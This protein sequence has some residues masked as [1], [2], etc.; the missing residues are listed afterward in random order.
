MPE[1]SSQ[2]V[3]HTIDAATYFPALPTCTTHYLKVESV[4]AGAPPHG[5]APTPIN[6]GGR[7]WMKQQGRRTREGIYW[8]D[9]VLSAP[10]VYHAGDD[11]AWLSAP[12][13][14]QQHM[15]TLSFP[16]V[17]AAGTEV[18]QLIPYQRGLPRFVDLAALPEPQWWR[19]VEVVATGSQESQY[20]VVSVHHRCSID[21]IDLENGEDDVHPTTARSINRIYDTDA[22][23]WQLL[24]V[25]EHFISNYV[26]LADQP[27]RYA[28]GLR[29]LRSWRGD[30]E[31][32]TVDLM[33]C[34]HP[35]EELHRLIA[36]MEGLDLPRFGRHLG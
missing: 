6:A 36:S 4:A 20:D 2:A 19:Y 7:R 33:F 13:E 14:E 11:H 32:V 16:G 25:N 17:P 29:R 24:A 15:Y 1:N 5:Y 10:G 22:T 9:Y 28:K 8:R 23:E 30:F 27:G 31:E 3:S 35:H 21:H 34:W 26:P 12:G 18:V